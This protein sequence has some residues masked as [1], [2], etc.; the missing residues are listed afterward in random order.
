MPYL[1]VFSLGF[2]VEYL[3]TLFG[4]LHDF[5]FSKTHEANIW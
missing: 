4:D 3:L 1:A 2:N 5:S